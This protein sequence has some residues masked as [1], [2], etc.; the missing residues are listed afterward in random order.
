MKGEGYQPRDK[1][2]SKSV[3]IPK[4]DTGQVMA[5]REKLNLLKWHDTSVIPKKDFILAMMCYPGGI[6]I[7]KGTYIIDEDLFEFDDVSYQDSVTSTIPFSLVVAW[8]Y[9]HISYDHFHK[10]NNARTA[11]ELEE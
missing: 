9:D 10:V 1:G 5:E 6:F 2:K 11:L 7:Q 4:G 8:A 3:N